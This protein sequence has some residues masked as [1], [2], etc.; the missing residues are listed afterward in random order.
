MKRIIISLALVLHA[1]LSWSQSEVG[2]LEIGFNPLPALYSDPRLNIN[3]EQ[4][5]SPHCGIS[6]TLGYGNQLSS[7]LDIFENQAH[8]NYQFYEARPEFKFYFTLLNIPLYLSSEVFYYQ[9]QETSYE[10]GFRISNINRTIYYERADFTKQKY[11]ITLMGGLKPYILDSRYYVE[12]FGG[13]GV[14]NR[15]TSFKNV[16]ESSTEHEFWTI[17]DFGRHTQGS[18]VMVNVVIG[19]RIGLIAK[20]ATKH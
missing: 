16:I 17:F 2:D 7:N 15:I 19:F 12:M 11:G 4:K 18:Q 1:G 5:I 3:L 8:S 10:S 6:L 9:L 13:L 14:A 20:K